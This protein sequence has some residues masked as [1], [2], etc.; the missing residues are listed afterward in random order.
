MHTVDKKLFRLFRKFLP[1]NKNFDNGK[2]GKQRKKED[3]AGCRD[4]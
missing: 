1:D 4:A 3:S 2:S